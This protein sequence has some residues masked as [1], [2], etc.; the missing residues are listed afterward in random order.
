MSKKST[1]TTSAKRT[2]KAAPAIHVD[3]PAAPKKM[4]ILDAAAQVLAE[5]GAAMNTATM[6]KAMLTKR[7]WATTGKTPA[8]TLH[9]AVSREVAGKRDKS[10]FRKAGRGMFTLAQ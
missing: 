2:P 5:A 6:V 7:I 8:A 1:K 10:R 3:Q 4:S 9:A